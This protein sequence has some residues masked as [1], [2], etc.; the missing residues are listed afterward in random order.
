MIGYWHA[1]VRSYVGAGFALW[2][3]TLNADS[4]A[5]SA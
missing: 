4:G 2:P 5:A 3:V 1:S